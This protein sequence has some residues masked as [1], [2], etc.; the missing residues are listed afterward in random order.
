MIEQ[1]D[2]MI[3]HNIGKL[4]TFPG[5]GPVPGTMM[6]TPE[7][8]EGAAIA[9]RGSKIS[10]VGKEQEV[11]DR[12]DLRE[13]AECIDCGGRCVVPG[14]VD[15]HTHLVFAGTREFEITLKLKGASYLDILE[16]G[17]GILR[18]MN[19]TRSASLEEIV[20]GLDER[21]D[22]MLRY[23]TTT[24][25]IKS[26]YGLDRET[27][28]KLLE[29]IQASKHPI[30]KVPTFLGPHA[31]PP[32]FK[33]D[34][35]GFIDLMIDVT[36]EVAERNLAEFAD[37]FCETGVFDAEQS[38]KFLSAAKDAGLKIK[39]HSD[40]IK[41]LGGTI[42]GAEL[43]ARSADHLLVSTDEDLD[44]M[45]GAGTVPIVL[46][47]T[48]LTIFEDRVPG[49]REMIEKDLPVAIATDINPNC[50]VESL[51]FIMAMACYRLRMTPNEILASVT[52][53]SAHA[54]DRS[55]RKGRIREGFDADIVVLKD[56]SFD[57]VVYN[58]GVNH[59]DKVILGGKLLHDGLGW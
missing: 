17:G 48:L 44:A 46:P 52:A 49:V 33:E 29:A 12:A 51:Q 1:K 10:L 32:E 38:R 36:N 27:E 19:D 16:A 20:K 40:E 28:I 50:M 11:W 24:V 59:V 7:I 3:L 43:G 4:Y 13:D 39:I 9:I 21:L 35:E 41:N 47:G 31:V 23:G 14:F 6:D 37:I 26:G 2:D 8:I 45:K 56:D 22:K 5:E 54:V 42:V 57:H 55:E 53:N 58:F 18:T 30:E 15:P 25:E 34:P